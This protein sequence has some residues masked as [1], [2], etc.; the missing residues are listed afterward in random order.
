MS[1][2]HHSPVPVGFEVQQL[3]SHL[4]RRAH[5]Q[6]EAQFVS[7]YG[8]LDVTS[9]QLALLFALN[10]MAGA[11]Q[12][13]L[14]QAIG[15]DVNTFSDLAKRS[16]RKGLLRRVRSAGDQRAF[17]L[18]LTEAGRQLVRRSAAITPGYQQAIADRLSP[19][20]AGRLVT[21]LRKMVGL[22]ADV[23]ADV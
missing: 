7:Y 12:V 10:R 11:S 8:A 13:E 19:G 15:L 18:Y 23:E 14:A 1:D 21:L 5:F 9:R 16:E 3:L 6:A 2:K 4:L 17:R 20:E 22:G